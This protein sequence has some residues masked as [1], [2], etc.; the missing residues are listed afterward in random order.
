MGHSNP[1]TSSQALSRAFH[2]A[3]LILLVTSVHH[4][5]GAYVYHT[6]WRL[7]VILISAL[8]MAALWVAVRLIRNQPAGPARTAAKVVFCL[9]VAL[10]PVLGIGFFEG[11]YN[12][13]LKNVL[14]FS[15]ASPQLM[16]HLFP[17]P[18]Y[19]LPNDVIFEA[20]G[21]TQ[22]IV[23]VMAC[24]RLYGFVRQGWR[25]VDDAQPRPA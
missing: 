5:Y 16:A 21:V 19:E 22:F 3:L 6:P 12:H 17:P 8:T 10:V 20:S 25:G 23:G 9:I 1:N 14:Y 18:A 15:G 7:H 24:L 4:A 2:S 13:L 11:G